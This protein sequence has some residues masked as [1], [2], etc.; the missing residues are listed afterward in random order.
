MQVPERKAGYN[1]NWLAVQ[2]TYFGCSVK[3]EMTLKN[4]LQGCL[5]LA[6]N[7]EKS[8]RGCVL[9][10]SSAHIPDIVKCIQKEASNRIKS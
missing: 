7:V 4:Y 6:Q 3:P 2:I 5:I 9:L 10:C 8:G 1:D